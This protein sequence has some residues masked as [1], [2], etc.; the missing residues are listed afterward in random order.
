MGYRISNGPVVRLARRDPKL[1]EDLAHV[2][3]LPKVYG[4][5]LLFAVPRDP[6]TLFVYWMIDWSSIFETSAPVDRQVHLRVRRD[7]ATEETSIA[8]EPMAGN[9][10]V[11]VSEPRET[12]HVEIGYY[13]PKDVWNS[14]AT[15]EVVTTPPE[16][17]SSNVDVDVATIPF[18]LSF[19][20]LIDLFRASNRDALSEIVSRFQKRAV[21][22]EDQ[23]LLRPEELEVFRAM[24][25]S[26]DELQAARDA[27]PDRTNGF[28]LRR[29][30]EALLG[31]GATSPSRPFEGSSWS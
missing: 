22:D 2:V 25:L 27:F 6:H 19:Q 13:Q 1:P 29:R 8:V 4:D 12:Y 7:D 15:S 21:S 9:C 23:L 10:Y 30:A 26:L 5:P 3:E 20:R 11:T 31:F 17:V 28:A 16:R 24:N 18:H 14:V